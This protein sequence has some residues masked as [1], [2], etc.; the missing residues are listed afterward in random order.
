MLA[1]VARS[2]TYPADA[3]ELASSTAPRA[4]QPGER[5]VCPTHGT[6]LVCPTCIGGAGGRQRSAA[7]ARAAKRNARRPRPGAR[8]KKKPRKTAQT[9]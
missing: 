9:S 4:P 1:P 7:K 6:P 8:G 5:L 3:P 2:R